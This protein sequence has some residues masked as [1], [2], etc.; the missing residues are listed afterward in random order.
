MNASKENKDR[1]SRLQL[2][3]SLIKAAEIGSQQDLAARLREAGHAA[4]QSSVSRDLAELRIGKVGGVYRLPDAPV[5]GGAELNELDGMITAVSAAGPHL[6]VI[7]TPIG[8]AS[9]CA[10]ALD[11][12]AVPEIVGTIAGD[13][14]VFCACADAEGQKRLR[15]RLGKL[16][17]GN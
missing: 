8:A 11:T 5:T 17:R 3:R 4:T 12:A 7:H 16:L 10:L 1:A 15:K 6:L 14:T 2:I 9:R 13:D